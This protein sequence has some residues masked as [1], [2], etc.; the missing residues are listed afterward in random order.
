MDESQVFP[1]FIEMKKEKLRVVSRQVLSQSGPDA[2]VEQ[3][4]SIVKM[5]SLQFTAQSAQGRETLHGFAQFGQGAQCRFRLLQEDGIRIHA[6]VN[7][8]NVHMGDAESFLLHHQ[9][10]QGILIA[11]FCASLI[12]RQLFQQRTVE[13]QVEGGQIG[14]RTGLTVGNGSVAVC[15][16]FISV[17]QF[18][19]FG[20]HFGVPEC[21]ADCI[22]E[23][24]CFVVAVQ[25]VG[26]ANQCIA[27]NEETVV[28]ACLR[29]Q[30]IPD[31]CP[32]HVFLAAEIANTSPLCHRCVAS[33]CLWVGAG[34]VGHHDFKGKS[35]SRQLFAEL[36]ALF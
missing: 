8:R 30:E 16:L 34:I 19:A 32:T 23:V 22:S 17:T 31:A 7:E 4:E 36:A 10:H 2:S 28:I 6:I 24:A 13:E 3:K 29:E 11:I 18:A 26:C 5:Q 1:G 35:F 14:I 33:F 15:L 21:T 27:V 20:T 12:K 9:P 25:E